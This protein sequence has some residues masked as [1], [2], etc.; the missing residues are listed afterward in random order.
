MGSPYPAFYRRPLFRH[1][2]SKQK[3]EILHIP[4]DKHQEYPLKF[5]H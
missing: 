5:S 3:Q 1:H 2:E 4:E